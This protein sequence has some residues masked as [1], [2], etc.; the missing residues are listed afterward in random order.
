MQFKICVIF[1]REWEIVMIKEP[2]MS[3][4]ITKIIVKVDTIFKPWRIVKRLKYCIIP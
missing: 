1:D 3:D 4:S 2:N